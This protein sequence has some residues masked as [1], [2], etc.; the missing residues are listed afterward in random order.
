MPE[1]VRPSG[2]EQRFLKRLDAE[3]RPFRYRL[4]TD[5]PPSPTLAR[6]APARHS[7]A[8]TTSTSAPTATLPSA[9]AMSIAISARAA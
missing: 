2:V 7:I 1:Y 8:K 9:I 6:L 5:F 3:A 4:P